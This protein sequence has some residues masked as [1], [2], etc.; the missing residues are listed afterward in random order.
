MKNL[1]D[2]EIIESVRKGN[3]SDFALLVDRYKNK[4]FSMLK[5]MLKNGLEAEE[6]L[7]DCFLKCFNSLNNFRAEAKFSTWFY[8]IVYNT[9]LT[10][11]AGKKRKIELEMQSIDDE[12][13]LAGCD[14]IN[15][16]QE[17]ISEFISSIVDILPAKYS[18]VLNLYYLNDMS[19]DEIA[20]ITESSTANIKV[21]LCRARTALRE[22]IEK[23]DLKK[24]LI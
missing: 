22:I 1:T 2:I 12:I 14:N 23:R 20:E 19:C 3:T 18:T 4:A 24:E 13:N 16:E 11:L 21:V 5:R 9:A 8:K 10:R 15:V 7:Q 6:A 17:N